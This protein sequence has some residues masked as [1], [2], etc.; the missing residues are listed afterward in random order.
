[1]LQRQLQINLSKNKEYQ[2][3]RVSG[4]T[5]FV[6]RVSVLEILEAKST[7]NEKMYY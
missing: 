2:K 4:T 5:V 7:A 1:M 3:Q 6:Q